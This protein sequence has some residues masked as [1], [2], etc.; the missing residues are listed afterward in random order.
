MRARAK[1][2]LK[3]DVRA[4]TDVGSVRRGECVHGHCVALAAPMSE[5]PDTVSTALMLLDCA[6]IAAP[7]RLAI[8][9]A[10]EAEAMARTRLGARAH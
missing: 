8:A 7:A 2:A 6:G 9:C 1:P 5:R 3:I 4:K 10:V